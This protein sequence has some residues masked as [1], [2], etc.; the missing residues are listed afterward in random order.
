MLEVTAGFRWAI[1]L[2]M[3]TALAAASTDY[4]SA[5]RKLDLI[6]SDHLGPGSRVELTSREINAYAQHEA[7]PGVR[8]PRVEITAAGLATGSA[9]VDFNALQRGQ[10]HPPGWLMSKLLEGERP[11]TVTARL[12][13]ANGQARVDVERVTISGLEIDGRTLDFLIQNFLLVLYPDAAVDRSFDL[14][15]HIERLEVRPGGVNVVIGR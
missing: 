7:P 4:D 15:H 9:A 5:K 8:N 2:A 13:S 3:A 11:V 6:S 12:T 14:S 1:P 10:G